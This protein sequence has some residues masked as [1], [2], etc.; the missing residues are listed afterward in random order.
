[1][2]S[3]EEVSEDLSISE[4]SSIY[5][6]LMSRSIS[7]E[8]FVGLQVGTYL[9]LLLRRCDLFT[10]EHEITYRRLNLVAK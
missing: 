9:N 8:E 1:M 6:G 3:Q 4:Q 10:I 2:A 5:V 7:A